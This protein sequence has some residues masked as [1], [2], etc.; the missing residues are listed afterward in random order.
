MK[1]KSAPTR[2]G[3]GKKKKNVGELVQKLLT[4]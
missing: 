3:K 2:S 1:K 4:A